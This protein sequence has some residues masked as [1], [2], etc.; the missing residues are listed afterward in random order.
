[1]VIEEEVT[2]RE[3]KETGRE[4]GQRRRKTRKRRTKRIRRTRK[5]RRR[6]KTRIG[7]MTAAMV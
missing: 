2:E 6:G 5:T 3:A 1:M 4:I 7:R